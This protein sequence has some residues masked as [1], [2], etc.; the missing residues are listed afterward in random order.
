[1]KKLI[2]LILNLMAIFTMT[3]CTD[4][5]IYTFQEASGFEITNI[6]SID[7]SK[8]VYLSFSWNVSNEAYNYFD[9]EYV[10]VNFDI[11]KEFLSAWPPSTAKDDAYSLRIVTNLDDPTNEE[12]DLFLCY[13]SHNTNYMYFNG[14][15]G[16][17]RSKDK[18]PLEFIKLIVK[19]NEYNE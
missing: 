1:M 2:V 13:I 8:S 6:S 16:T 10:K 12:D 15:G 18:M 19:A 17:Y 4:T 5:K 14:V 3:A 7:A 11:N 9:C